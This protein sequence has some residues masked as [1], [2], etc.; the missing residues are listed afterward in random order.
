MPTVAAVTTQL[1]LT[2]PVVPALGETDVPTT[3]VGAE[4]RAYRRLTEG[5]CLRLAAANASAANLLDEENRVPGSGGCE[6]SADALKRTV[7]YY[8]A[9]EFR[10]RAAAEALERFFQLV[11]AEARTDL[12]GKAF[13]ITDDL[14]T[15]AKQAKAAGVRFPLEVTDLTRQR[16][17]LATELEQAEHGSRLLTLDL[18]RR[19]GLPFQPEAEQLWGVGDF[20]VDPTPPDA[21]QAVNAALADR[22]E[23]RGLRALYHGLTP[24]TLPE[25]RDF[26]RAANPMLGGGSRQPFVVRRLLKSLDKA[27]PDPTLAAELEVRRKQ[28]LDMIA[29]KERAVADETRAA[30]MAMQSQVQRV[31]RAQE[32]LKVAEEQLA[33]AVKK[34]EAG[35]PGADFLEPQARKDRMKAKGEVVAEV[36]AWHQARVRLKAAQGWLAWE[37]SGGGR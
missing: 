12:L 35:Q 28:L 29:E 31:A 4:G 1:P 27:G 34:R 33:E 14:L 25:V 18:K 11:D 2:Q 8:S 37:A 10:N 30:L 7:R 15:K 9:L 26:L 36:T 19:L 32:R 5:D 21:E 17:Q 23:L 20:A 6:S 22:P 13:P 3:V 24:D 16:S